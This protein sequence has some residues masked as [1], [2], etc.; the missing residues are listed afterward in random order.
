MQVKTA[1]TTNR[2]PRPRLQLVW[3]S[4]GHKLNWNGHNE[5]NENTCDR[6]GVNFRVAAPPLARFR[7]R[8]RPTDQNG[9][10]GLWYAAAEGDE[11]KVKRVLLQ[12]V[13]VNCTPWE[14][15]D[16]AFHLGF[17]LADIMIIADRNLHD[18]S[19]CMD[20]LNYSKLNGDTPLH[21]AASGG[22]V[23]V[24]ELLLK[25]GARVD[26]RRLFGDTPIHN[27]ASKGHVGVVELLLKAGAQVDSRGEK[28]YTPLHCAASR[29]HVGVAELLLKR[30]AHVDSRNQSGETPEDIAASTDVPNWYQTDK[31]CVLEG[32][33][34]I[35]ELFAAEKAG[36]PYMHKLKVG[37]EGGKLQTPFCTVTVPDGAVTMETEIT[38]QVIDPNDVTLPLKD[39]EMLVSD[40][41]ELGPHGTTFHKPVTVQRQYNNT[42]LGDAMEAAVW[43]S[44]DRSQWTELKTTKLS[45]DT[46]AVS[47]DHFSIFAVISQ[48]KQDMFTVPSEGFKLTSSTQPAVQISFPEQAVNTPTQVTVQV[49]EV[50]KRAVKDMNEKDQSSRGLLGTSPIV[51][52]ETVSASTVHVQFHKPVTVRVPHP[53]HYMDVQ[54]EGPTKL[55]VMSCEEGTEDWVDET[56]NTDIRATEESV[57]FEVIHFTRWIVIVVTDI[58]DD[59]VELGPIPLTLCRWLQH[60]AV[61]FILMQREDDANQF[62]VECA[63]IEDAEKK[64]AA[65]LQGGYKGPVPT[66]TVNLFEGQIVEVSLMG[67]V[68]IPAFGVGSS[69]KQQIT[70]HSQKSNRLHMQ[71]MALEAKG[72]HGLDGKGSAAFFA[73]PRV[74]VGKQKRRAAFLRKR[75]EKLAHSP[76]KK[77]QDP[78]LLCQLPIHVPFETQRERPREAEGDLEGIEKYFHFTKE[79]VSTDWV[80]V[81]FHLGAKWSTIVNI[82][83]RNRDDK[84]RC[85]DMLQEWKKKRGDAATIEVLMEALSEAG[86]QSVVDGLKNKFPD[87]EI[88]AKHAAD[89]R[90]RLLCGFVIS[91]RKNFEEE[92]KEKRREAEAM[93]EPRAF[94]ARLAPTAL[95]VP[96][97]TGKNPPPH[98]KFWLRAWERK[99]TRPPT[100]PE[101]GEC[102]RRAG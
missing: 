39:G 92:I 20:M 29:G 67:N 61:Q 56:D 71:V 17:T 11:D 36:C 70:F 47:V 35:L 96:S 87:I 30:G 23:G 85:M 57:E 14:D 51:K 94:G 90:R 26:C 55:R 12:F 6:S 3:N 53:Q 52:V 50:P 58:Y 21:Q 41:I 18:K 62:V 1:V 82:A 9:G 95:E 88:S 99:Q 8:H 69:T 31:D 13:D 45:K 59:P 42:S 48:P 100:S 76:G 40:I 49:Q 27:A 7:D 78:T 75:H 91:E 73:L 83:G 101:V 2:I 68:S 89:E 38:C 86:L 22:H 19:C 32:R 77:L 10:Q 25:A 84:S 80:D 60:R 79:E 16:L 24:A 33:K 63:Q 43:V 37:P 44:E 4:N 5:K 15:L 64:R 81:A 34:K 46:L 66:D 72:Q 54:H 65:L 102:E 97:R 74:E 93:P 98:L 28:F